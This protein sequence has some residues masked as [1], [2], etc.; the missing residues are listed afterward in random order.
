MSNAIEEPYK[1]AD[2]LRNLEA[3]EQPSKIEFA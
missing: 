3:R 2:D 1:D